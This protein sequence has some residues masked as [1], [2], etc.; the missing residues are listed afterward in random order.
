MPTYGD[1]NL[2]FKEGQG[3]Y[4]TS[5]DNNKYRCIAA[6]VINTLAAKLRDDMTDAHEYQSPQNLIFFVL[7]QVLCFHHL[8]D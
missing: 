2:E 7:C 6:N 5:I 3:C 8:F 4:L 1:R